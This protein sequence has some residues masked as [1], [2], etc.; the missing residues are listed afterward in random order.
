MTDPI[1]W[2]NDVTQEY[3]RIKD[4]RSMLLPSTLYE[5]A[6]QFIGVPLP[7]VINVNDHSLHTVYWLFFM[8][9]SRTLDLLQEESEIGRENNLIPP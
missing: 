1:T 8:W 4:Y 5:Q 7:A 9:S 3:S 6:F 2:E